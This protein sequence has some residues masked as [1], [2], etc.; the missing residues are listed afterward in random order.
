MI[1]GTYFLATAFV[2][3]FFV[4]PPP[5]RAQDDTVTVRQL[6]QQLDQ[7]QRALGAQKAALKRTRQQLERLKIQSQTPQKTAS[8]E[9]TGTTEGQPQQVGKAPSSSQK[10]K[11]AKVAPILEQPGVLTPAGHFELEPSLQYNYSTNSRVALVGYTVI[12]A[13]TIGLIDIREVNSTTAVAALT[14]RYGLTNRLEMEAKVPYLYRHDESTARPLAGTNHEEVFTASG[15]DLGDVEF[16]LRYQFNQG[17]PAFPYFIGSLRAIF[18]TGK[19]PFDVDYVPEAE[20]P[21]GMSLPEELPTGSGS[22]GIEPGLQVIYPSDPAVFFAGINYLWWFK[23][24]VDQDIGSNHIGEVD[25]GDSIKLNFGM[26]LAINTHSSFSMGY[27]HVYIEKTRFDGHVP[28][29]AT[30]TQLSQL[31]FGYSYQ[32]SPDTSFNLSVAAGLT[33]D[34]PD[35]ELTLR[36]PIMF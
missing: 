25:P 4:A 30:D 22:Y 33:H 28:L 14:A 19:G 35:V 9:T 20:T 18:P 12:P 36:V 3:G 5:V 23:H 15:H 17:G 8:P 7:Q 24:N 6:Q 10:E 31:L 21:A 26:G 11:A 2:F 16:A 13:I 27:Q 32:L 29:A 1:R 34:T